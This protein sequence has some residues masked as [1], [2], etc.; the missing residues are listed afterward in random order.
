MG[1]ILYFNDRSAF[2]ICPQRTFQWQISF[3]YMPPEKLSTTDQL[4]LYAPRE[5]FNNRSAFIICPQ[6]TFQWQ[7]SFYY[8][9]PV[10]QNLECCLHILLM[11]IES[12]M[13]QEWHWKQQRDAVEIFVVCYGLD[14]TVYHDHYVYGLW[15]IVFCCGLVQV[16]WA[17]SPGPHPSWLLLWHEGNLLILA[18][19]MAWCLMAPSHYLNQCWLIGRLPQCQWSNVKEYG[20]MDYRN[21]IIT[22][23]VSIKYKTQQNSVHI[24]YDIYSMCLNRDHSLKGC[25]CILLL[26]I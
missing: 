23:N 24:L 11:H 2:I 13:W 8:M 21:L 20:Y 22:V 16:I 6:R 26:H 9:P 15:F 18:Q 17:T 10:N 12:L 14:Y 1:Y 3:Y 19:V 5:P 4:L 7:I 25:L